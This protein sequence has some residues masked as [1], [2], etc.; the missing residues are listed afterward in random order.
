MAGSN[1]QMFQDEL[2]DK[3]KMKHVLMGHKFYTLL[4]LFKKYPRGG[5]FFIPNCRTVLPELESDVKIMRQDSLIL[6]NYLDPKLNEFI[7]NKEHPDIIFKLIKII[8]LAH[9]RLIHEI[10]ILNTI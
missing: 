4:D 10:K 9:V 7:E 1:Y 2:D 5:T 8:I 6:S 3:E